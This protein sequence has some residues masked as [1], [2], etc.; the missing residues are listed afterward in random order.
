[1]K[2]LH[3][4]LFGFLRTLPNDATFNQGASV[5]RCLEKSKLTGCSFGYDLSAATDRLP[6]TIQRAIIDTILPGLGSI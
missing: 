2:P 6:V 1:M 5:K 4:M 3:K